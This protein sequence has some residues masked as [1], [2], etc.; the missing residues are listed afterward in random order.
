MDFLIFPKPTELQKD[1]ILIA[2]ENVEYFKK[3][4]FIRK[5]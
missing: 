1:N 3:K 5:K 4:T 2:L